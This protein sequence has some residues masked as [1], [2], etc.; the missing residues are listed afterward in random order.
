MKNLILAPAFFYTAERLKPFVV[1]HA[2][3]GVDAKIVF[4]IEKEKPE[5]N[6]FYEDYPSVEVCVMPEASEFFKVRWQ[7]VMALPLAYSWR[8]LHPVKTI[9]DALGCTGSGWPYRFLHIALK[10][11]LMAYR[12]IER[13]Y[14]DIEKIM[15]TDT[16]D[17]FFQRDPFSYI[18]GGLYCGLE[19]ESIRHSPINSQWINK[20]YPEDLYES[21]ADQPTSCSG[22]TFGD[23]ESIIRYLEWMCFETLTHFNKICFCPGYDQGIHN[24]LVYAGKMPVELHFQENGVS[25]I[26]AT[27]AAADLNEFDLQ[28]DCL[29]T[30][31][32]DLPAVVHQYQLHPELDQMVNRLYF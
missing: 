3:A 8:V 9:E 28:Q 2:K 20:L 1:S 18:E 26:V 30:K 32:G 5:F 23:R 10:R 15:L 13:Q 19:S 16:R 21:I 31:S 12:L 17:V 7:K 29:R 4:L 6:R 24:K 27:M 25:P 11:Y 22:V 14:P